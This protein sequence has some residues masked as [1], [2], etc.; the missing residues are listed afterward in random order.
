MPKASCH[1]PLNFISTM[2]VQ[3]HDSLKFLPSQDYLFIFKGQVFRIM[4]TSNLGHITRIAG[5]K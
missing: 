4:R 5:A 2:L 1:F 3:S